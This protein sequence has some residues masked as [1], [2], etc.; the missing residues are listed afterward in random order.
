METADTSPR[1][2]PDKR[3]STNPN[4]KGGSGRSECRLARDESIRQHIGGPD[5]RDQA[6]SARRR[7]LSSHSG[8]FV[9]L[10]YL[11]AVSRHHTGSRT[12]A[13][14]STA[15]DEPPWTY[16]T[17]RY[18]N[19][20]Q[21]ALTCGC[22]CGCGCPRV[23]PIDPCSPWL[24]ARCPPPVMQMPSPSGPVGSGGFQYTGSQ[25]HRGGQQE[26]E[27]SRRSPRMR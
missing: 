19:R 8:K 21:A 6:C 22:G 15:N 24:V 27:V 20:P 3:R 5:H 16:T 2:H 1:E 18:G 23:T 9:A 26:R 4:A 14:P 17:K 11:H 25:D 7:R 10:D 13:A 12:S